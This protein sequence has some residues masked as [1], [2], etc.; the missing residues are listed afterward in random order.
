VIQTEVSSSRRWLG[1]IACYSAVIASA[2][3]G[4]YSFWL[5]RQTAEIIAAAAIDRYSFG[6]AYLFAT[7]LIGLALFALVMAGEGYLRDGVWL[8]RAPLGAVPG[9][10]VRLA[11][12]WALINVA[13]ITLQLIVP[14]LTGR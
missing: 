7:L 10:V 14:Q 2:V 11:L 6:A 4:F 1:Y 3:A 13:G 8:G 5:W 12:L 9:R